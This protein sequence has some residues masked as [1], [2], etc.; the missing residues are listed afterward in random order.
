MEQMGLLAPERA[1]VDLRS[2]IISVCR[3]LAHL[4]YE[5]VSWFFRTSTIDESTPLRSQ[6]GFVGSTTSRAIV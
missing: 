6:R 4:L 2:L 5:F 3:Q 1:F